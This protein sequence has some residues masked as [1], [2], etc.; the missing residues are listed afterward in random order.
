MSRGARIGTVLLAVLV[1]GCSAAGESSDSGTAATGETGSTSSSTT[2]TIAPLP[3]PPGYTP[4]AGEPSP[5]IKQAAAAVVQA[6]LTYP[7]G[8]GTVDAARERLAGRPAAP[9]VADRV[10]PLLRP[11]SASSAEIVYPQYGGLL[12]STSSVMVVTRIRSRGPE[13]DATVVR[14]LDVRLERR[15]DGWVVTDL[16][17]IGGRR[18][19]TIAAS[20]AGAAVLANPRIDL[21]TSARWDILAGR[22]DDRVLQTLTT[23]AATHDL[24]ITTFSTGHPVEVFGTSSISNHTEGRAVDIWGI[25]NQPVITQRGDE[26]PLRRLV[27]DVLALGVTELGSPWALGGA[28]FTNTL[29]Q[30]HLHVAYDQ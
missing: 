6:L 7:V 27:A 16:A 24:A 25:D 3:E 29:H 13:G 1:V 12:E 10:V 2:T 4:A 11:R 28:S 23:M 19:P 9:E 17:S 15:A 26:S 30:D 21:P 14:T 20:A 18:P 22:V 5:E 8:G